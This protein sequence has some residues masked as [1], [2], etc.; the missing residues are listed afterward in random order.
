MYTFSTPYDKV[1][2]E[3]LIIHPKHS[4]WAKICEQYILSFMIYTFKMAPVRL[5]NLSPSFDV[6]HGQCHQH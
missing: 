5:A 6:R 3:A 1:K 2:L 4:E